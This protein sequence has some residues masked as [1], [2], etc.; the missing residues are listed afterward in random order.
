MQIQKSNLLNIFEPDNWALMTSCFGIGWLEE[1]IAL[2]TLQASKVIKQE[3]TPFGTTTA[4]DTHG[5]GS[6]LGC[7]S[8]TPSFI[9]LSIESATLAQR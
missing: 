7:S 9:I 2:F 4:Q 8:L 6:L 5:A 3:P 1:I